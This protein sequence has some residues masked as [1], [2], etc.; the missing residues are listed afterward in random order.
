MA[1]KDAEA[2]IYSLLD[3]IDPSGH[4]TKLLKEQFGN[5]SDTQFK[6]YVQAVADKKA[7]IP[8][9]LDNMNGSQITFEN[10]K[11]LAEE[12]GIS[13]Y[14]RIKLY[15]EAVGV[16]YTSFYE[17]WVAD[18]PVRRQSEMLESKISLPDDHKHI[19]D[20][21]DQ[22][23]GDS[24]GS[25]M[26]APE[27]LILIGKGAESSVTEFVAVRG[28]DLAAMRTM[29]QSIHE[30]GG[31]SLKH[32]IDTGTGAKASRTLSTFLFGMHFD[33]NLVEK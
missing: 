10:N 15:D 21:T 6:E 4:N 11:K 32:A 8:I 31:A 2:V 29:E 5:L 17:S 12:L 22:P 3:R 25:S 7:F 19:D 33:N 27:S 13:F 23:V 20:Y 26:S 9:V 28:G 24:K 18:L 30:T 1:R 14:Q 16:W